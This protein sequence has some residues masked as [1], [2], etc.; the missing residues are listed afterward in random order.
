AAQHAEQGGQAHP[1]FSLR[2]AWPDIAAL[3]RAATM[4]MQDNVLELRSVR[5]AFGGVIAND[6]ITMDVPRGAIVGLIGPNGSGKTT[7]FNSIVGAHPID[8]G[9]VR[10]DGLELS[11]L[12]VARI[13]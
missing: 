9:S 10:F 8:G 4:T 6:E 5:K 1:A 2:R 12:G 7:L 13:A 3:T 11:R